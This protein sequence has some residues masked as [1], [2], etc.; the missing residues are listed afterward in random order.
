MNRIVFVLAF[1]LSPCAC[2]NVTPDQFFNATV[3]CATQNPEASTALQQATN[4]LVSVISGDPA[5]CLSGL[6]TAGHFTIDEVACVVAYIAQQEQ[7]KVAASTATSTDLEI[8]R[9]ATSWL[10]AE[11]IQIRNS[12]PPKQ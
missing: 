10:V 7:A 11:K 5:A 12:Y 4:C 2:H 8:R 9:A 1:F 6:I 3:D